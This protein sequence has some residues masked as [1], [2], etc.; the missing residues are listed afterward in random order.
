LIQ[1]LGL[2]F[3]VSTVAL[4]AGLLRVDA[5]DLV[6]A[7]VSLLAVVPAPLKRL[8]VEGKGFDQRQPKNLN[9]LGDGT[10]Q[11]PASESTPSPPAS[12]PDGEA[13]PA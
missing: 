9:D 6:H 8:M 5:F 2:S 7:G 13:P 12:H 10:P 4:G 11:D 1:A 3:T